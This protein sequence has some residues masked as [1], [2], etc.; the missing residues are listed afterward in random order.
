MTINEVRAI[1]KK[2]SLETIGMT[3]EELHQYFAQEAA[4]IER[5]IVDIRKKRGIT[6]GPIS[7]SK[8]SKLIQKNEYAYKRGIE[9]YDNLSKTDVSFNSGNNIAVHE[10]TENY[11]NND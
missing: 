8:T 11:D 3:T 1:K 5:R 7:N 6:F 9:Y 4:D 10:S 2:I